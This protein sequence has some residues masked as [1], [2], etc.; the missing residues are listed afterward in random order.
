VTDVCRVVVVGGGH[1][2][3]TLVG[4]LRQDGFRG[5]IILFGAETDLPYHRPPLSKKFTDGELAQWLRDPEFYTEQDISIRLGEQIASID[6]TAKQVV[7]SIGHITGYDVLVLATGA[8]PRRLPVP[9]GDLDGVLTLRTLDDARAVRKTVTRQGR[10]AIIGGGYVGLEVAAAARAHGAQI[11]VFER[12]DR[13]LARV[14]SPQL[15]EILAAYHRERG[16]KI[17]TG[18]QVTELTGRDG[19]VRGVVQ[20]D[21]TREDCDLVLVGVGAVPRDELAKRAGLACAE[22]ILVDEKAQTD[23]P[24]ILAIGDVTRR[25]LAGSGRLTRL[26]SIPSAVEQ[27]RQ[28]SATICGI[29]PAGAEVPW[30][31]SDQFDLKLKIAGLLCR[32]AETVLRGDPGTGRFAL[33]HHEGGLLTTV[34]AANSPAEFMAGRK[35][36][37]ARTRID[38]VRLADPTIPLRDSVVQHSVVH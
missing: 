8:E 20:A 38:P 5:E 37:A 30:F 13:V 16:T 1:A 9:G 26:E 32:R 28:A 34:E 25:P 4:R 33:F 31:W 15:S 19:R 3:G 11:T 7:S 6:R 10:I 2:G 18:A 17:V 35:F 14:A 27:A 29:V 21:G 22:G 23:D 12:E 36:M 24:A